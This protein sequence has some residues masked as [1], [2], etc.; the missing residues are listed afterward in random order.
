MR[1]RI[2]MRAAL[3]EPALLGN[4]L[5]GDSWRPW[6]VLLIAGNGEALDDDERVLFRQMTQRE[7]EPGQRVEE[8]IAIVGQRG[9]KSHAV[10][11]MATHTAALCEHSALVPG[12]R[13]VLL[14]IAPD[15]RQAQ[16]VLDY[17]TA[18]FE[19]S[20]ILRQLIEQ[21]TQWSL[22]LMNGVDIEVRASDW[23]RLR[24]LTL[25]EVIADESGYFFN[26][27]SANPDDEI[28]NA[29][30]PGLA[31]T[32][33]RLTLISSPYAR[34]GELWRSYQKHF[35]PH[36]DPRILVAQGPSRTFNPTLPQSVVDR[37]M[38]RD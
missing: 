27:N 30:R 5:R 3:A 38:E 23:R 21:R 24:G 20:P 36:G 12:E 2:T 10:S 18:A 6:R 19:A 29:V 7:H 15:Q 1:A 14:I 26:E 22:R 34:R 11:A 16:I 25:I 8:L 37:A 28:L 4:V 31:T 32:S 17:I 13:G 33:G 9:G 35:G